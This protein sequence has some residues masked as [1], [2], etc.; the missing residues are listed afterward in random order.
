MVQVLADESVTSSM[1]VWSLN[2]R[3]QLLHLQ[4]EEDP[5]AEDLSTEDVRRCAR[6]WREDLALSDP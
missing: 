1:T 5:S 4:D 3:C 2:L 6:L